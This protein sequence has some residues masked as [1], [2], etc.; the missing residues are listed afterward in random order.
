MRRAL[1]GIVAVRLEVPGGGFVA[2]DHV[3]LHAR[4][5]ELEGAPYRRHEAPVQ[6]PGQLPAHL[7]LLDHVIAPLLEAVIDDSRRSFRLHRA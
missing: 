4:R 7:L 2:G 1:G 5:L 3:A 6:P